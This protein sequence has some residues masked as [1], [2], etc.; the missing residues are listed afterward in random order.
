M[1]QT[2]AV[3]RFF[4]L[5]FLTKLT[6]IEPQFVAL[7]SK[8]YL[9]CIRIRHTYRICGLYPFY[10]NEIYFPYVY[11]LLKTRSAVL[12][13]IDGMSLSLGEYI[14]TSPDSAAKIIALV[15][16]IAPQQ[17]HNVLRVI[18]RLKQSYLHPKHYI[19]SY[20]KDEVSA[21]CEIECTFK[22]DI[23]QLAPKVFMYNGYLL[24]R[25]HFE[26]GVFLYKHGLN[27]LESSTLQQIRNKDIID[28]GGFIGDS[29]IVFEREFCDKTI[30]SFEATQA[31]FKL[32]LQTLALNQ[33]KRIVPINKG[34]GAK[35]EQREISVLGS[36]STMSKEGRE[37]YKDTFTTE[38]AH[39]IT[40]DDYVAENNIEVGFIKVD[41]E[42]F[43]QA[44]LQ[45]A[46]HTIK[47]QK[48]A[49]LISIYHNVSDF[50]DIKPL[51]ESWDLGYTFKFYKPTEG[52]ISIEMAL[53]C[54]VL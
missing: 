2:K 48:P 19:F 14:A 8:K 18:E 46:I 31:N 7:E 4:G 23:A 45:G 20:D 53:Y 54:E 25:N 35:E 29:A 24:P 10:F 49:M 12:L 5:P 50:F 43:E 37:R 27:I 47:S 33:S 1:K 39:I 32:M 38:S 21:L 41:I 40:L 6:A 9:T 42:G 30:H 17:A 16:N 3:W 28:V 26:I 44:F 11:W 52:N 15:R 13:G 36:G 34:L 22:R 51:I